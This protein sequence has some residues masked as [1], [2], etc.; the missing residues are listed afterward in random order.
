MSDVPPVPR[1]RPA[2]DVPGT[3][4]WEG[5]RAVPCGTRHLFR[6]PVASMPDG[7]T[8][9]IPV[10]VV[11]G[12]KVGPTLVA[13]AGHHGDEHEGP[14]ALIDIW[15]RLD[16]ETMR[17][18]VVVVPVLNPPAFRAARRR[19][20]EDEVDLNRVFPGHE[21]STLTHLIAKAFAE[22]LLGEA[23]FVLSM[24]GW[25]TGYMVEPYVEFPGWASTSRAA[26]A[27][28]SAFGLRLVNPLDAGP[29]RLMTEASGRG[30]PLIEVEIGGLGS[31]RRQWR[32]LYETGTVRL[33]R[34]LGIVDGHSPEFESTVSTIERHE[35]LATQ[36]GLLRPEV[37]VGEQVVS[38]QRL[39]AIHD[40]NLQELASVHAAA[41]GLV[42]VLRLNASVLP[43]QLLAT[44]FSP[45][46][47]TPPR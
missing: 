2:A 9:A 20:P 40:L 28:A 23:D 26:W 18:T 27:A 47:W 25:S 16:P 36:G 14:T 41:P 15:K 29:G 17:G 21:H 7:S 3:G 43:G 11:K 19:S 35:Y 46:T 42:G 38:G 30:I 32:T 12:A 31:S 22:Q 45:I 1:Q 6:L 4:P 33:L 34:H 8:V 39:G 37:E 10:N 13:V 5:V 24:H 44:V